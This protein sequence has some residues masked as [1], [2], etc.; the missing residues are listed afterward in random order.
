MRKRHPEN[1]RIK[2]KYAIW[3]KDARHKSDHTVDQAL[4]AIA[5]FE[6]STSHKDFATFHIEKARAFKRHLVEG[7]N[8]ATGKPYAKATIKGRLD[9]AKAFFLWL[10]DQTGYRS[11]IRHA[12]C[13][14]FNISAN[15]A[16]IATAKRE[17][18]APD[19]AQVH[20]ALDMMPASTAIEMRDRA[21]LA[22]ALLTGA[23]DDA[24]A[25]LSICHLDLESRTIFQDARTVR[26]KFRKSFITSFFPVGGNAEVILRDW[27]RFLRKELGYGPDDPLFP[28]T[29]IGLDL[30]GQFAPIGL[31]RER[32]KNADAIRD[33][34]K[35]AFTNAGLPAYHP[36]SIRKTLV[37]LGQKLCKDI[38]ALTAWSLNLGHE[39]IRTTIGSYG[40]LSTARR[41]ELIASLG[42]RKI[43]ETES[44]T[45]DDETVKRVLAHLAKQV[46]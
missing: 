14:Y 27:V 36:H 28:Q 22:L 9:A 7:L 11:R 31:K 32:W 34:F 17:R 30:N 19:L 38:E 39:D 42:D 44:G 8:P 35:R 20:C 16:R 24:L 41:A 21:I 10:A 1:E 33:V 3:L 2:R 4:A 5:L 37:R 43:T 46:A 29:E 45:P 15:D 23:R 40:D 6:A 13:E 26:T 12:D 18:P 25:S